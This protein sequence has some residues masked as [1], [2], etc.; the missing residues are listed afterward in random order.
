MRELTHVLRRRKIPRGQTAP[1]SDLTSG[2]LNRW[3]GGNLLKRST[4]RPS[5]ARQVEETC[6]GREGRSQKNHSD[7][8][9]L[10]FPQRLPGISAQSTTNQLPAKQEHGH[11]NRKR[12]KRDF[13][14]NCVSKYP[15]RNKVEISRVVFIQLKCQNEV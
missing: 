7:S 1:L 14:F 4:S 11:K 12:I 5:L 9:L 13:L 3:G 8:V 15:I 6:G 10:I 2:L